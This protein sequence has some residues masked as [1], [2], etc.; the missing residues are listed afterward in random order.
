MQNRIKIGNKTELK[1]KTKI[2]L[3]QK[4]ENTEPVFS[5]RQ[6][7]NKLNPKSRE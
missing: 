7:E 1:Q 4:V 3:K 6:R 2:E 5:E